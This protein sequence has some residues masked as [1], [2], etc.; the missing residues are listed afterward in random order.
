MM[1]FM[2]RCFCPHYET[3]T[4]GDVCPRALTDE[5]R[6][7]ANIWWTKAIGKTG[8]APISIFAGIKP[9]CFKEINAELQ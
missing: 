3:C 7:A 4:H 5:V 8:E 1:C 6:A 9:D 2:D